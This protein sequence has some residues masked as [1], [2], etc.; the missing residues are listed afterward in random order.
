MKAPVT[1]PIIDFAHVVAHDLRAPVRA[2]LGFAGLAEE[3][4]TS[5]DDP[6]ASGD[7]GI[8]QYLQRIQRSANQLNGML[9]GLKRLALIQSAPLHIT[10]VD[11]SA[12]CATLNTELS[13]RHAGQAVH[14]D[15]APGLAT[16]AD[17]ALLRAALFEL[18]DNA[19]KYTRNTTDARI[20][21]SAQPSTGHLT[22]SIRDNGCGFN[23]DYAKHLFAP[24]QHYQSDASL[25]G[26]GMG[27]AIA[28]AV[29]TRHGGKL[30]VQSQPAQ[31]T[32][33][34]CTLPE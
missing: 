32:T 34:L 23:L 9:D 20:E 11:V 29:I 19:W 24:F 5:P 1:A 2:I 10:H 18:L 26:I 31:G 28:H 6:R 14:T 3:Q 12:L 17:A 13:Q 8:Q 22:L 30:Q 21:V 4:L 7:I 27:L 15:I 25:N 33:F 16:Q